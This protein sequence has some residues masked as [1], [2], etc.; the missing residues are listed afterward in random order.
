MNTALFKECD[1]PCILGP[2]IKPEENKGLAEQFFYEPADDKT[3]Y[4]YD[5]YYNN[6]EENFLEIIKEV[7]KHILEKLHYLLHANILF[8]VQSPVNGNRG[9]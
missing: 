1:N 3:Q 6:T 4:H 5:D 8:N 2:F 7:Q 9:F